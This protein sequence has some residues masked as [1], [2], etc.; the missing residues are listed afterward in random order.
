MQLLIFCACIILTNMHVPTNQKKKETAESQA[1]TPRHIL[2]NNMLLC[3]LEVVLIFIILHQI[4][5][6]KTVNVHQL[7]RSKRLCIGLPCCL[8]V[9]FRGHLITKPCRVG[10]KA[11]DKTVNIMNL[12][13]S[14]YT[15]KI[16]ITVAMF[17]IC[18][19]KVQTNLLNQH[20]GGQ[21]LD[22]DLKIYNPK[23]IF[24]GSG[25]LHEYNFSIS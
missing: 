17:V 18:L 3:S 2:Q 5:L 7:P 8:I 24:W 10:S 15:L 20:I 9:A 4:H 11:I 21:G 13:H 16:F 1:I 23:Q 19:Y 6:G 22:I 25:L 14:D 12:V